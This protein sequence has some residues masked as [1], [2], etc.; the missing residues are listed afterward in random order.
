MSNYDIEALFA[1]WTEDARSDEAFFVNLK[2]HENNYYLTN[3][4]FAQIYCEYWNSGR[5]H[6]YDPPFDLTKSQEHI[7]LKSPKIQ[8]EKWTVYEQ[9]LEYVS[10]NTDWLTAINAEDLERMVDSLN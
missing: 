4:P 7:R 8:E 9:A 3:T 6:P 1:Q 2:F 10:Q 5:R